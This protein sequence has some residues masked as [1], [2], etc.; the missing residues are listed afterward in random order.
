MSD[1]YPFLF[2][3]VYKDYIWGGDRIIRKYN[4][5]EPEGIYAESWEVSDRPEGMSRIDNG[6]L[7]GT[8]LADLLAE[9][10]REILGD[11]P[12]PSRF[13]LLIKLIDSR[14]D[15]SL[16]VHPNDANKVKT[17][18]EAKTEM[19]YILDADPEA[20]VYS[21]F[22]ADVNPGNFRELVQSGEL[23]KHMK[24]IDVAPG[25][26]I[27]TPGGRVHAIGAGCLI[28]EVQQ[29]S[30][31]TYRIYDWG[32]LGHDGKPRDLH[33]NESLQVIEWMD[34]TPSMVEQKQERQ[35]G[36]V[37][38]FSIL[39][40]PY[41]AMRRAVLDRAWSLPLDGRSFRVLFAPET[42]VRIQANGHEVLLEPGRCCLLPACF[43][44]CVLE[45]LEGYA[46]IIEIFLP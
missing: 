44:E 46:P 20:A 24:R 19:W 40:T 27:F 13:P 43:K 32:R 31:T 28:L 6:A 25:D 35:D 17:G 4:R 11:V 30:N 8:S 41:F 18:G 42:T 36:S 23:E 10:G 34:N 1:L 16:Q 12:D 22:D 9:S 7:A 5:D 39:E 45:P 29:N 26:A 15:L 37:E 14:Q 38:I 3:P 2:S 21:G 33:L